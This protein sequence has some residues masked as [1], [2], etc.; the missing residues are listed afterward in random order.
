MAFCDFGNAEGK[1]ML[2]AY[3]YFLEDRFMSIVD[4]KD[5]S[6]GFGDKE[7]YKEACL[8]LERGEHMGV[9]GQNGVGKSTLFDLM[10]GKQVQNSGYITWQNGIA[11]GYL[12]QHAKLDAQMRIEDYLKT[13]FSDLYVLEKKLIALYV[14]MAEKPSDRLMNQAARYQQRLEESV[15]YQID[16]EIA[17]VCNGLGISSIGIDRK[18]GTLSGGQRAKVILAKLLLSTP[19][20]LLLDEPTNFLDQEHIKWLT[21]VLSSFSG[22]FMIISHDHAFLESI[23]NCI[24]DIEFQQTHKYY[25]KF[26]A[27]IK[28]KEHRRE[29]YVRQYD[30]Q[31]R[32]IGKLEDYIAR[33]K[34][35]ASTARIARGRQKMLDRMVRLDKATVL[36]KPVFNFAAMPLTVSK[37]LI[38]KGLQ[39]GYDHPLFQGMDF[40]IAGGEKVAISGFNGIGKSTLLKTLVG[41]IP[42][43]AGTHRFASP[44]KFSYFE[45]DMRWPDPTQTPLALLADAFPDKL[46]KEIRR[47]LSRF[48]IHSRLA[49]QSIG[50]LSGGE[51]NRVKLCILSM[52]PSNFLILD[53]PTNHL[54]I[55]TKEALFDALT[56]YPGTVLLVSHE[57]AFY[58]P[59]TDRVL[60]MEKLLR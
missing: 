22:S 39:V 56:V 52:K 18:L 60:Q 19:D 30:A 4:I 5:L 16:T 12:D 43:L 24:C 49:M 55:E 9:V 47:D 20:V 32:E 27:F 29:A 54:D 6:H 10:L 2:S 23:T 25:G 33:N 38:V 35:R 58:E 17:R 59:L 44:V 26:S 42:S 48:G 34:V 36:K 21:E 50:T 28:Q 8:T 57:R 40:T 45:Q 15:F 1:G 14:E 53:E 3:F 41:V 7:L 37:A 31:Q 51:Q 13:A 11:I 46:P